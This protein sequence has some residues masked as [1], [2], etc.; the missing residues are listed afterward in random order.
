MA[1][2]EAR[3]WEIAGGGIRG[4]LSSTLCDS[5]TRKSITTT[6]VLSEEGLPASLPKLVESA[7]GRT[8]MVS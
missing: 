1:E 7:S 3:A 2:G 6:G 8:D 5:Q 4:R